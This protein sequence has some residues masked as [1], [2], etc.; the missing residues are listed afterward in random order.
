M[1]SISVFALASGVELTR[2]GFILS[3]AGPRIM[4][5]F[6]LKQY[7]TTA[8]ALRISRFPI[9]FASPAVGWFLDRVGLE[10]GYRMGR[11]VVGRWRPHS[12]AGPEIFGNWSE[13][14]FPGHLGI[15]RRSSGRQGERNLSRTKESRRRSRDD[16]GRIE[17]RQHGR[18]VT[19]GGDDRLAKSVFSSVRRSVSRGFPSG[20]RYAGKSALTRK[21]RHSGEPG[22]FRRL[23]GDRRLLVLMVANILWMGIYTLWSNWT[24]DLFGPEL[25]TDDAS[26][27]LVCVG[28]AGGVDVGSVCRRMGSRAAPL[29]KECHRFRRELW[30]RW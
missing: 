15:G 25:W 22:A 20:S 9:P 19:C 6:H 10:S 5:E 23:L 2:P 16:T 14:A 30:E 7:G 21:C 28:S 8:G 27:V 3:A 24:D 11:R 17:Y 4:D 13:H 29:T 1:D 18:S 12:A 26:G